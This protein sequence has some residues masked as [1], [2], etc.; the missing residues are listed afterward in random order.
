MEGMLAKGKEDKKAEQVGY[1]AFKQFCDDT[2]TETS[3]NIAEAELKIEVLKA[4]IEKYKAEAAR[5]KEE[6]DLL[7]GDIAAWTGDDTAATKVRDMEK[8]AY[9]ELHQDYSE[10]ISALGRAIAVLKAKAYDLPQ[11]SL[12]Q[13]S[14][15]Q[16]RKLIPEASRQALAAFLQEAQEPAT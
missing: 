5:L 10:S 12:A 14:A 2:E 16:E 8:A 13:V 15:L 11:A 7:D 1:A 4:D 3:R 6:A 9:E